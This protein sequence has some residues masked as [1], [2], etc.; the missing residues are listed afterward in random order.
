M[1]WGSCAFGD[2][3]RSLLGSVTK[4]SAGMNNEDETQKSQVKN[5]ASDSPA[6]GRHYAN[7][8][9]ER[10]DATSAHFV[11]RAISQAP[12]RSLRTDGYGKQCSP[13]PFC[14]GAGHHC[15]IATT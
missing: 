12:S 1:C 14:K 2:M 9:A 7:V 6:A 10:K 11:E 3:R 5:I 13:Q 4:T 8:R 15:R